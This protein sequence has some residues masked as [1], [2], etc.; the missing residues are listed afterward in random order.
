[1]TANGTRTDASSPTRKKEKAD[2]KGAMSPR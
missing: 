2:S 1:M